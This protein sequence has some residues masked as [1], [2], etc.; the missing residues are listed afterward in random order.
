MLRIDSR[1]VR[2]DILENF[3]HCLVAEKSAIYEEA[4]HPSAA[5]PRG[6]A[7]MFSESD[8]QGQEAGVP[9]IRNSFAHLRKWS[10]YQVEA[11]RR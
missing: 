7:V 9:E 6:N 8:A 4:C 3:G 2:G 11:Q 10:F 5:S 1:D